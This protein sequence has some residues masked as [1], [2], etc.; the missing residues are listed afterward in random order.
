M[1][2]RRNDVLGTFVEDVDGLLSLLER[3][4]TIISG[5]SALHLVQAK[6]GSVGL[7][8]MDIY[9][10]LKFEDE[11][12]DYLQAAEGYKVISKGGRKKGYDTSAVQKV[13]ELN[14]EGKKID[15]IITDWPNATMPILQCHS[16]AVMNY[17]TAHSLVCLYPQWTK[18]KKSL[19][20]PRMYLEDGTNVR[21]VMALMKYV[22]R[23]FQVTTEPF[24]L[25]THDCHQSAY[26]PNTMRN[27]MDG[28]TLHW[29]FKRVNTVGDIPV[30]CDEIVWRL[31]GNE[32]KEGRDE[33]N[34]PFICMR[35]YY[36]RSMTDV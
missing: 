34:P 26:C 6:A 23:G 32:C 29:D 9:A 5:S 15:I 31:G 28:D 35:A 19:V 30:T 1:E 17:I 10:T 18:E 36:S 27:T 12:M 11:V 21:G 14:K 33:I 2:K 7:R 4:G 22:R 20:N 3:T 8:D 16:T 25:G 24:E 13:S